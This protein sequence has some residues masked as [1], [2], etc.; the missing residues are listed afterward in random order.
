MGMMSCEVI[1]LSHLVY[2]LFP[3]FFLNL[4]LEV[5]SSAYP[6]VKVLRSNYHRFLCLNAPV[7]GIKQ[8]IHD[9]PIGPTTTIPLV[10]QANG[11]LAYH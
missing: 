5:V 8:A 4:F 7:T 3:I 1:Y 11:Y 10:G 6:G 2:F 9:N